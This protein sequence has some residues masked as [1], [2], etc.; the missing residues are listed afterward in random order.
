MTFLQ[1]L[2]CPYLI[3]E[4]MLATKNILFDNQMPYALNVCQI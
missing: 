2:N 3:N 4:N 1:T